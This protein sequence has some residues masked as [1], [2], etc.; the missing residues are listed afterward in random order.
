MTIHQGI[1]ITGRNGRASKPFGK[2]PDSVA[3]LINSGLHRLRINAFS[4]PGD[5]CDLLLSTFLCYA[6]GEFKICFRWVPRSYNGQPTAMQKR[7]FS[8]TEEEWRRTLLQIIL[9]SDRI[10]GIA[11]ANHP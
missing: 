5:N 4:C 7:Y 10:L 11:T 8:N 3:T 9:I 1:M 2:D 6:S